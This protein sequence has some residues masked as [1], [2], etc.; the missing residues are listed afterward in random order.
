MGSN[1]YRIFKCLG[2]VTNHY[3]SAISLDVMSFFTI[4]SKFVYI[5]QSDIL[6]I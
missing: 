5:S 3:V 2:F 6:L 1:Y 4:F